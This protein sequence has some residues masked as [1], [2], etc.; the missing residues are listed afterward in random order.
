MFFN[1]CPIP[2][3]AEEIWEGCS[4]ILEVHSV[5]LQC[6]VEISKVRRAILKSCAIVVFRSASQYLK[7]TH[8]HF[9]LEGLSD[10]WEVH[11]DLK[12]FALSAVF[13]KRELVFEKC[14]LIFKKGAVMYRKYQHDLTPRIYALHKITI[15]LK[16]MS[17]INQK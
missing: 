14:A 5:V 3:S 10:K 7:S 11:I 6:S 15:A 17:Y 2:R 13:E 4:D 16:F 9:I 8:R 12:K 1:T